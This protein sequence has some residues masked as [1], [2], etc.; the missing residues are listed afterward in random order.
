MVLIPSL[1]E[2]EMSGRWYCL[3]LSISLMGPIPRGLFL[4]LSGFCL[5][6]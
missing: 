2:G 5:S 1:I 6:A 4:W 3:H